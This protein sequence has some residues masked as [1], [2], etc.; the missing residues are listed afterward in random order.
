MS[1]QYKNNPFKLNKPL[2]AQQRDLLERIKNQIENPP[3]EISWVQATH[4]LKRYF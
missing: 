3:K 1:I 2:I 4:K